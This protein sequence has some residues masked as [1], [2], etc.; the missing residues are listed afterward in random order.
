MMTDEKTRAKVA[1]I[2][3]AIEDLQAVNGH[4]KITAE[5]AL[6]SLLKKGIQ[7]GR[8]EDIMEILIIGIEAHHGKEKVAAAELLLSLAKN[9]DTITIELLQKL[10]YNPKKIMTAE[11]RKKDCKDCDEYPCPIVIVENKARDLNFGDEEP[12]KINGFPTGL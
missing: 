1:I 5:I 8:S 6:L 7:K 9:Q 3:I 12:P 2:D 4:E 11:A 10:G